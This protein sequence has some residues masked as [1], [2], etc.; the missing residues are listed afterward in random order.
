[1][2]SDGVERE[3]CRGGSQD[4]DEIGHESR[5][6]RIADVSYSNLPKELLLLRLPHDVH[7]RHLIFEAELREHLPEV[8]GRCCVYETAVA[9]PV[10]RRH[11]AQCS[12]RIDER[13][14]PDAS[15]SALVQDQTGR[16]IDCSILRVH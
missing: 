7:E 3:C 6:R 14:C 15:G 16:C 1:M 12:Q 13:R 9:F 4:L 5:R 11:H 10:H 8:G 2:V